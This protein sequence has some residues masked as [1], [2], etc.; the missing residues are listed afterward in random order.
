M[1]TL[2]LVLSLLACAALPCAYRAQQSPERGQGTRPPNRPANGPLVAGQY[3]ALLIAVADY[4]DPKI[5]DLDYPL[6]DIARVKQVLTTDYSFTAANVTTLTNPTRERLVGELEQLAE[7][8]SAD[9]HLLVFYAGHGYWDEARRQGYWLPSDARRASK[10]NWISNGELRDAIR[11]IKARHTLLIS[12]ACFSGS[13]FVTRDA[14]VR[15][16]A[17]AEV[18]KLPSRTAMTSGA[19]TTVP[20]RSVFVQYL[21]DRLEK[22]AAPYVFAQDLFT[23]LRQPVINNSKPQTDGSIATPRYGVIQETGDEGGDFIF[24]RKASLAV[25]VS[26]VDP[27]ALELALWQSADRSNEVSEFEEYLRQYPSG[28]FAVSARNRIARLRA[29]GV[30]PLTPAGRTS[31]TGVPLRAFNFE[32]ITTDVKGAIKT[33]RQGEAWGFTED[34]NGLRLEMVELEGGTFLMGSPE[35]EIDRKSDETQHLVTVSKFAIGKHEVT[36][37]Q[38]RIV[39]EM[40]L[41]EIVMSAN[42]AG[43]RGEFKGDALPVQ[44]VTWEEAIEFCARL[45]QKTGLNY[46]LPTEAEWE[47]AA[48]GGTQT[49]FAFGETI[50]PALVN[51]NGGYPYAGANKGENRK[52]TVVIGSLNI[53]NTFGLFDMH[54]NLFEICNDWYGNYVLGAQTNPTG[55]NTGEYRVHRGGSFNYLASNCRSA[56]RSWLKPTMRNPLTGFRVVIGST[57]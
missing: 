7:R 41:V 12:D 24:L 19:L 6:R 34:V 4:A 37:A 8:L 32:T 14:F 21:I 44:N 25:A 55:P 26:T 1:K 50:S 54:G 10:T 31:I 18:D 39:K 57:L 28:R 42:P 16:T 29:P 20:D 5:N 33:R 30:T 40:P 43:F 38:W 49:A 27:T 36:Q 56:K 51:Y 35:T 15:E 48:R 17:L 13:M 46:R 22:N 9:D 47:Y 11:A 23:Q 2:L 52:R 45:K 3:H 53:P